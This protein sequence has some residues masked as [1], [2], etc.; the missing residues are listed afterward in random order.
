MDKS[1][2][3]S[4]D[5]P[6]MD[7]MRLENFGMYFAGSPLH[8]FI[9]KNRAFLDDNV[10]TISWGNYTTKL[11]LDPAQDYWPN[12]IEHFQMDKLRMRYSDIKVKKFPVEG[13][14][15]Y[16]PVSGKL[17]SFMPRFSET[18]ELTAEIVPLTIGTVS[19]VDIEFNVTDLDDQFDFKFP[20]GTQVRDLIVDTR[21]TVGATHE[22]VTEWE[23]DKSINELVGPVSEDVA[24]PVSETEGFPESR[25][26]SQ[27]QTGTSGSVGQLQTTGKVKWAVGSAFLLLVLAAVILVLLRQRRKER[28]RR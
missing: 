12:Q 4:Q 23:I 5:S 28:E 21:Y 20:A 2:Y 14:F 11:H 1:G 15:V 10:L 9:R 16:F 25:T 26:D 27:Q 7:G 17:E 19:L 24:P 3:I 8:E 18:G 22:E 6:S 13:G